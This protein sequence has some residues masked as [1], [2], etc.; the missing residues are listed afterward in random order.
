[1]T[2]VLLVED[3]RLVR[4]ALART[5]AEDPGIEVV[6]QAGDGVA[7][8]RL[9]QALDPD[10]VLLDVGLPDIGGVDLCR[11]LRERFPRV[12]VVALS[13][14][15]DRQF[16][17]GMLRAGA[18]GYV[19]KSSAGTQLLD[20]IRAVAQGR[21][22][23]SPEVAGA[24][25]DAVRDTGADAPGARLGRRELDVLRLIADGHRSAAIAEKLHIS[26]ST[27]EVHRRNIMRKLDLH[28]VAELTRYAVRSRL[29][30]P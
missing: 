9:V 8:L 7:A 17:E 21:S 25:V 30:E 1:M 5:L 27:V 4:E 20:A 18:S 13:A 24:V 16:V 11:R 23:L 10:V 26:V 22:Y 28:S 19:S 15:V 29:V 3:H 12:R 6:G 14:Y 2:R